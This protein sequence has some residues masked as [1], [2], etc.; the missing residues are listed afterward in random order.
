MIPSGTE[1][2]LT[3]VATH[4]A[5]S[6]SSTSVPKRSYAPA[7]SGAK[8][9]NANP[10][11]MSLATA[12]GVRIVEVNES[13]VELSGY[14]RPELIGRASIDL[15]WEMPLSRADLI[16]RV[17]TGG[18]VRD[19]ESKIHTKSGASRIVLLSSLMVEIGGQPCLLSVS[20]DITERRRAEE[21]LSLLQAITMEVA[22]APD[23]FSSI[24]VCC[25]GVR[26]DWLG[27]R[28]GVASADGRSGS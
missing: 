15:L 21:Q 26:N 19:L 18:V 22:V 5:E 12:D 16:A 9:F 2:R 17:S 10:H 6:L 28:A 27:A 25:A 4:I 8:A 14:A 1:T 13:F 20:N 23:L 24:E 7:A 3:E 11:P